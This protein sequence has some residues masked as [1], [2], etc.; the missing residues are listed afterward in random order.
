MVNFFFFDEGSQFLNLLVYDVICLEYIET[1][2]RLIFRPFIGEDGMIRLEI[3]PEDSEGGLNDEGLPFKE[4][5]ELTTNTTSGP[6]TLA[7]NGRKAT[8]PKAPPSRS[9]P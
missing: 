5:A 3:H 6:G 4:T 8:A 7:S 1:G 2:T 9:A